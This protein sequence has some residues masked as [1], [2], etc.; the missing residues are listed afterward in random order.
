MAGE[1]LLLTQLASQDIHGQRVAGHAP[2]RVDAPARCRSTGLGTGDAARACSSAG[3]DGR[4]RRS[5][6]HPVHLFPFDPVSIRCL[7]R[8]RRARPSSSA[9]GPPSHRCRPLP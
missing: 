6:H 1:R 3:P 5:S 4:V 9:D 8:A 7:P 2:T